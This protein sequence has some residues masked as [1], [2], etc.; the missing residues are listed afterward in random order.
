MSSRRRVK[1]H[2]EKLADRLAAE[3]AKK[4]EPRSLGGFLAGL[5]E[6]MLT[7]EKSTQLKL[8]GGCPTE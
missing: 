4:A 6:H 7:A 5:G 2:R 8:G 3:R 1:L